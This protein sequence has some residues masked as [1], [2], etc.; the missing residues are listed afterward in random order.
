M[1]WPSFP[2][3]PIAATSQPF[4][5][6]VPIPTLS[7]FSPNPNPNRSFSSSLPSHTTTFLTTRPRHC[8]QSTSY[9]IS[10]TGLRY[11]LHDHHLCCLTTQITPSSAPSSEVTRHCGTV[12]SDSS[13]SPLRPPHNAFTPT[14]HSSPS[15]PN[16]SQPI[17][18]KANLA[19][20]MSYKQIVRF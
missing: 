1:A 7:H 6:R 2:I 13:S 12:L 11:L 10:F 4:Q 20:T 8:F 15:M 16:T 18:S 5:V 17:Y 14:R 19:H 3:I 9:I